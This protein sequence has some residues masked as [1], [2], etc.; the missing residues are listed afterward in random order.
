MGRLA[1]VRALGRTAHTTQQQ[2]R[3]R[4]RA[5]VVITDSE[6][7]AGGAGPGA[8]RRRTLCSKSEAGCNVQG[9]A[10]AVPRTGVAAGTKTAAHVKIPN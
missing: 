10:N 3:G 4:D 2:L 7:G 9:C 6:A 5:S 8:P 1:A